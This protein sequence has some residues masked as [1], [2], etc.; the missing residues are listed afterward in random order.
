[1]S[2]QLDTIVRFLEDKMTPNEK[3]SFQ[4]LM[5]K[6]K[7]LAEEVTFQRGLHGFLDR[8]QPDLEQKLNHLGDEFF[9]NQPPNSKR[10]STIWM[11]LVILT[12]IASVVFFVFFYP[13]SPK[14]AVQSSTDQPTKTESI[15]QT[16]PLIGD[17]LNHTP[18]S[19]QARDSTHSIIP[20]QVLKNQQDTTEHQEIENP[21]ES[22]IKKS[23]PMAV[24][25]ATIYQPNPILESVIQD[26]HRNMVKD[27]MTVL[28]PQADAIFQSGAAIPFLVT[29]QTNVPPTYHMAVYSNRTFDIENNYPILQMDLKGTK[30]GTF[31]DF[32]FSGI[33]PL[34]EGLYYLVIRKDNTRDIL[35]IS[36]FTVQ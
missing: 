30:T 16:V 10:T 6:D 17:T 9:L 13:S 7:K 3:Q 15:L 29:G 23:Q 14:Q 1:M 25:D 31:Y 34:N 11:S 18:V 36:K 12:G 8:H 32:R 22:P 2:N 35:H 24:L 19:N 33:V 26:G 27:T 28:T 21:D 5:Q 4:Q 20:P